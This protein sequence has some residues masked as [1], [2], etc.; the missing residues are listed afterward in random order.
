MKTPLNNRSLAVA[1]RKAL[2]LQ[3]KSKPSRARE[4]A[5]FEFSHRLVFFSSLLA[6]AVLV[7]AGC[8][9]SPRPIVVGSM[10]STEQNILGEIVAQHLGHRLGRAVD[11]RPNLGGSLNAYQAL[12]NGEI[13]L[14][15][16]YTGSIV[17]ELLKEPP[18]ADAS[19]VFERA[20]GEMRRIAQAELLTPLGFDNGY[21]A[22]INADDP[23][24]AKTSN[25]SDAA[26]A[27]EGWKLGA[28]FEF[29]QLTDGLPSLMQ[30]KLPMKAAPRS[31]DGD[32]LF[33]ALEQTSVTMIVA[34]STDAILTS[35]T[36]K[37]LS[38]D[39]HHFA[40]RQACL[41]VKR[42]LAATLPGLEP[43]LAELSGKI[44]AEKMRQMNAETDLGHVPASQVASAFLESAG[45]AK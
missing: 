9:N 5:V 37:T 4:Q 29:Q 21:I 7:A 3:P 15:P 33:K 44:T 34:R 14:Y 20:R 24:A 19:M 28:S 31:M 13:S 41:L 35:K 25:L 18:A 10:N 11:R 6:L 17:T 36:W 27:T 39:R 45:L 42:D 23:R 2:L 43:A 32:L 8:G 1:A 40:P 38:D 22:V 30:Y 26:E 12:L 16:E